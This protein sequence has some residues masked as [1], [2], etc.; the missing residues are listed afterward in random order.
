MRLFVVAII[1]SNALLT[2]G[3]SQKSYKPIPVIDTIPSRIYQAIKL[4]LKKDQ[5]DIEAKGNVRSFMKTLYEQ[6]ADYVTR[7]F[8]E[9]LL[10]A[11]D[12]L[13]GL[14][15]KVFNAIYDANPGLPRET[16]LYVYRDDIPNAVS[17]GEGTIC[18]MLGLLQRVPTE[19]VLAYIL[20]H[21][22]AHYHLDHTGNDISRL[23]EL[24]YDKVLKKQISSI[25]NNPYGKYSKMKTLFNSLN[26][27]MNRHSRTSEL[28]ADSV[29]L[30]LFLNTK[31][32]PLSALQCMKILSKA[33]S[34]YYRSNFDLKKYFSSSEFEFKDSWID[35]K[36]S[37][38]WHA[39]PDISDSSRTHPNCEKRFEILKRQ[40]R[41][42]SPGPDDLERGVRIEKINFLAAFELVHSHYHF[43]EYGKAL[44]MSMS[45]TELYPD[46][47]Y[48]HA[49]IVKSLYQLFKAQKNH[50][51]GKV[52]ELPDPRFEE[53]YNR[54]L[55]FIHKLR[56]H[57]LGSLS[58]CYAIKQPAAFF[59]DEEFLHAVWLTSNL[60][61]S[62]LDPEKVAND[63]AQFF[64]KGKYLSEM[65]TN[66]LTN[67]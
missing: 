3:Q 55:D 47:P 4:R 10:M 31:Y 62:K 43:K 48:P 53:N 26:L 61:I 39:V 28:E 6:R 24:N 41:A 17:F 49:M 52:M 56:L 40:L 59:N 66:P 29:G 1:L 51:L 64:P 32:N 36:R 57:E 13:T 27:S 22:I 18:I 9:D 15:R 30:A 35:Y 23:A 58:Y 46:N 63:Y 33:D 34:G 44:Y 8:N 45:L 21:E 20:C 38:V 60:E 67:R 42:I 12:E 5:Q 11:E 19:D 54:L 65:K 2:Q 14:V 37:E 16:S 50:R 7:I 25:M